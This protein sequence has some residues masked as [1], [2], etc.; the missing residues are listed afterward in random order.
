[1]RV[2]IE[3]LAGVLAGAQ[4][5][6]CCSYDEPIAIPS[7]AAQLIAL[8]TQQIIAYETGVVNTVDPLGGSYFVEALTDKIESEASALLEE[9]DRKGGAIEAIKSG[10]VQSQIDKASLNYQREIEDSSRIIVGVNAFRTEPEK[11]TPG[12]VH[13]VSSRA[14]HYEIE[15]LNRLRRN[16]DNSLLRERLFE[17]YR[18]AKMGEEENLIPYILE[19]VKCHGT[20]EEILGAVRLAWGFSYEPFGLRESTFE[21]PDL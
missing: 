4:S 8:R 9:I 13:R 12:G 5:L 3:A 15:R 20:I 14:E 17:L 11:E 6:H 16:R 21:Y 1:V 19:A 7:E 18:H 2:S 10:W